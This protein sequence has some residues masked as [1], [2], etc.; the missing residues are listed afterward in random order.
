M[1]H[2]PAVSFSKN[3]IEVTDREKVK[4]L[5]EFIADQ[6]FKSG[7][8]PKLQ[9]EDINDL[10][11]RLNK[12]RGVNNLLQENI[13]DSNIKLQQTN[14]T[15]ELVE[16]IKQK[17]QDILIKI[18]RHQIVVELLRDFYKY[19]NN[20]KLG[21]LTPAFNHIRTKKEKYDS[22]YEFFTEAKKEILGLKT[23]LNVSKQ[24]FIKLINYI[25]EPDNKEKFMEYV[26]KEI[27]TDYNLKKYSGM[28]RRWLVYEQKKEGI[29]SEEA[30]KYF[31]FVEDD[32]LQALNV[33]LK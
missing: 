17:R 10:K 15:N 3:V 24:N 18:L 23:G 32:I 8:L 28:V 25:S 22:I 21:T 20:T 16:T 5:E 33:L 11:F 13:T 19:N 7:K 4:H 29:E 2:G 30:L 6:E 26:K 27:V 12:L 14:D 1:I 31:R 9:E